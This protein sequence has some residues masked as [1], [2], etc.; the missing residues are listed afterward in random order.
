V[1][2]NDDNIDNDDI[3]RARERL[4]QAMDWFEKLSTEAVD[5]SVRIFAQ[6][7]KHSLR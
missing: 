1:I 7:D 5:N 4:W 2:D 3:V 6:V